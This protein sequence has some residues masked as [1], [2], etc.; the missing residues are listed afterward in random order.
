VRRVRRHRDLEQLECAVE[1]ALPAVADAHIG[2]QIG[3]VRPGL[4]RLLVVADRVVEVADVLM[5]I[6]ETNQR[7][8]VA[9]IVLDSFAQ[10][11][12]L[13]H[14]RRGAAPGIAHLSRGHGPRGRLGS[15]SPAR[16]RGQI[17][18]GLDRVQHD[19]THQHT[20]RE[21]DHKKSQVLFLQGERL[22]RNG[23]P[24]FGFDERSTSR[25]KPTRNPDLF[26]LDRA[27][28]TSFLTEYD[29]PR[30]HAGQIYRW[31][32]ACGKHNP[33]DWTD[34]PLKLRRRLSEKAR[35]HP[36]RIAER[37]TASDGT[38]KYRIALSGG[39]S[40]ETVYMEQSDRVTLCVSSQ[41]G[42]AL[43]CDFC[44]TGK[45]G[46]KRHMTSGEILGQIARV[47]EDRNLADR[48]FSIV[49]MGMGEPLHNYD[50]V[51]AAFRILVDD[52]GF[53]LGRRRVTISTSGLAP[54]IE[55]L[56]EEPVRPRL[57]VSLN[58]TTDEVRDR[59]MPINRRY[60]LARLKEACR[61][62]TSVSRER[63]TFEYVLL[64]GINCSDDDVSRLAQ[65]A[66]TARAKINL[67]PF[68][69]VPGWL[70]YRPPL[71]QRIVQIRDRL[72]QMQVPVSI[73][74][75]RGADARAA[76]GQLALLPDKN[77]PRSKED[78]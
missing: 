13:G 67:I 59:L 51:L 28:L 43:A 53:G 70:R 54:A 52:E 71:R 77:K 25:A 45:M 23:F 22:T 17:G 8:D 14:H 49:F 38:I 60:P 2:Q 31:M 20:K 35:V 11:A 32:Y 7:G 61:K 3:V 46:L 68:N 24:P 74:W 4:E 75:S 47:R 21:T 41:V 72:L 30:F 55:K 58:A 50:A 62:F 66:D 40:V 16:V 27:E 10:V 29:V 78:S 69:P 42:C 57:A 65:I 9:G 73:R 33:L 76:C 6:G 19:R 1:F 63:F 15:G 44:L 36:G 56:A 12:K 34:L 64:D 37:Q 39:D 18:L 5:E 48:P 26:G